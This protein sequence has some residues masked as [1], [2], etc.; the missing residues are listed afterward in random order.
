MIPMLQVGNSQF[1]QIDI[2][3]DDSDDATQTI[4]DGIVNTLS[5]AYTPHVV[6]TGNVNFQVTRGLLGVS[7]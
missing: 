2:A 7:M 5:H 6:K 4:L 3:L 1:G